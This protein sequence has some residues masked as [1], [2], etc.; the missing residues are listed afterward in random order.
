MLIGNPVLR[1]QGLFRIKVDP[2]S[3]DG[4]SALF[5][6][7]LDERFLC[8]ADGAPTGPEV[9]KDRPAFRSRLLKVRIGIGD[10]IRLLLLRVRRVADGS[11]GRRRCGRQFQRW[12]RRATRADEDQA[13]RNEQWA[14][15]Q[16]HTNMIISRFSKRHLIIFSR[17]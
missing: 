9:E 4:Q 14:E 16:S 13:G 7:L 11:R 12:R 10:V 15:V 1:L 6:S 5:D 8:A 17:P 3:R 2:E